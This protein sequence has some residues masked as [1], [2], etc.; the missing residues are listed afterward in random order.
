MNAYIY[1]VHKCY[2][3]LPYEEI[4]QYVPQIFSFQVIFNQYPCCVTRF[5][6]SLAMTTLSYSASLSNL[7]SHSYCDMTMFISKQYKV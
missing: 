5:R 2:K 3:M 1:G 4:L 7:A 6:T